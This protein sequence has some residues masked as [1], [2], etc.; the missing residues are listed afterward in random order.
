M[1][2]VGKNSEVVTI[3]VGCLWCTYSITLTEVE[4]NPLTLVIIPNEPP[5]SLNLFLNDAYNNQTH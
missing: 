2:T 1:P 4:I 5:T 3:H